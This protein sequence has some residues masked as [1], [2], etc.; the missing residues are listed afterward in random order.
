MGVGDSQACTRYC[1]RLP[2]DYNFGYCETFGN[3]RCCCGKLEDA[4]AKKAEKESYSDTDCPVSGL[5]I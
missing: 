3:N 1:K 5:R 2:G 4:I